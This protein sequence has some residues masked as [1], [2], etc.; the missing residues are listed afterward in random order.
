MQWKT[1][2]TKKKKEK[3]GLLVLVLSTILSRDPSAQLCGFAGLR[4]TLRGLL[5][6]CSLRRKLMYNFLFQAAGAGL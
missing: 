3:N 5:P 1:W 4:V 2:R 6:F